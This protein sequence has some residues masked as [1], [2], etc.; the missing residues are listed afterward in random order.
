LR[1]INVRGLALG[2]SMVEVGSG[3]QTW[4]SLQVQV[5]GHAGAGGANAI[6]QAGVNFIARE[7]RFVGRLYNDAAFHATIGYG[8]LVHY[9]RVGTNAAAE[10]PYVN[11]I[12]QA[13]A[14]QLLHQDLATYV[15]A[16]N[17]AV[18]V[19]LTQTQFDALVSFAYN[20]GVGGM[21]GSQVVRLVNAGG[22]TPVQIQQAFGLWVHGNGVLIPG[23]VNR[24]NHE[25][26]LFNNGVY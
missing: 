12:T 24:R 6:S 3:N 9:G 1:I 11:G 25:T 2:T 18:R 20:I 5:V 7:E 26:N 10:A 4:V 8:H 21:Q 23:L 16:V 22:C 13:Q 15:N 14:T 17:R 19:P